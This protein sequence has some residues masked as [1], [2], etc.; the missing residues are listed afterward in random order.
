MLVTVEDW[1]SLLQLLR[2][3]NLSVTGTTPHQLSWD[4]VVKALL[5]A[6]GPMEISLLLDEELGKDGMEIESDILHQ[7]VVELS[8]IHRQQRLVIPSSLSGCA[9]SQE[10]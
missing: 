7:L 9:S 5:A 3:T 8:T 2:K 10:D 6:V 1:R 4:V